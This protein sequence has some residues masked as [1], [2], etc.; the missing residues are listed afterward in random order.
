MPIT[1]GGKNF[2]FFSYFAFRS[3]R[4]VVAGAAAGDFPH[5][6]RAE[7]R[8]GAGLLRQLL[9]RGPNDGHEDQQHGDFHVTPPLI[10]GGN[11]GRLRA[12]PVFGPD[13]LPR[14]A[15]NQETSIGQVAAQQLQVCFIKQR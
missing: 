9:V 7:T 4:R 14:F 12:F 5:R 2:E 6:R 8:L 1:G 3:A 13:G 15:R 11:T 10:F